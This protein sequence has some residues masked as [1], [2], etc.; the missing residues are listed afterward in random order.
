M[1]RD[2]RSAT[3]MA[4]EVRGTTA[5]TRAVLV[6]LL[7]IG[8][9][10]ASKTVPA[11]PA[12]T[13]P[14]YPDYIFPAA[15][16]GVGTPAAIERHQAG[17]GWLQAGDLRSAERNFN[18]AL[19]QSP[20]FY[21]AEAGLGYV[22]LAQKKHKESL[23]HFDRAVVMNPRY[24]PALGGRAEA[25]LALGE[26]EEALQSIEAALQ[27]DP[28]LTGL[29]TRI[30]V[31]RF[32]G[33]QQEIVHAR[34]LAEANKFDEARAAYAAAIEASPQ[35]PFLHRELA[36]VERRAGQLDSALDHARKASELEPDEPR[37]HILLGEIYEARGDFAKAAD[38]FSSAVTLQ[39]DDTLSARIETLRSRAAFAAMPPEYRGIGDSA[40]L[41]RGE[42][43]A[44]LAVK[45][46][47]LLTGTRS[48]S[49]V[50]ITDTRA[51]WAAPYIL[52]AARAGLMDVYPNHTFLPDQVV[53]RAEMAR[54][55]GKVLELIAKRQPQLASAWRNPKRTFPDVAPGHLSYPAA[56]LAVEAD[57]MTTAADGSFQLTRPVTGTE[58]VAA[59]DKLAQLGGRPAR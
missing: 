1:R 13:T 59:V 3:G 6:C 39:P 42:L 2:V 37:T 12:V 17:W 10:C 44:L 16:A 52:T 21:P 29:R 7:V 27:A 33:Q 32:R 18:A 54:S 4:R 26:E 9:A 23:V 14:Q 31:L 5:T 35:S 56:A 30:Q 36:D 40:G 15:P 58:A 50:V 28:S 38:E 51:H 49:A 19:K 34:Q 48:V 11:P 41:T 22:A 53:R 24:A 8:T 47:P 46:E 25:L 45:L 57:V 20:P 43:A 55:V